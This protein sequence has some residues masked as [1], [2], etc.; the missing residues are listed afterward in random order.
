MLDAVEEDDR[1]LLPVLLVELPVLEDRAL[2][3]LHVRSRAEVGDDCVDHAGRDIAQVAVGLSDDGELNLGHTASLVRATSMVGMASIPP[4]PAEGRVIAFFDVDNTLLRGASI[5]HLGRGAFRRRM[6]TVSDLFVFGWQQ[7]RFIAVGENLRHLERVRERALELAGGHSEADLIELANEVYDRYIRP[8]LWP[9][10]VTL[11]QDHLRRGHEV[12]LITATPTAIA[13]VIA[14]RL[15]LTGA[16]GTE[17]EAVDGVLTGRLVGEVL[18][19]QRKAQAAR[20]LA[21]RLGVELTDSWAYSDSRNDIP[22][23][24]LVGH[25]VVVNPDAV[26]ARH[27]KEH[28]WSQVRLRLSSIRAARRSLRDTATDRKRQAG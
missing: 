22:L 1:D 24:S 12:W 15:G 16:L 21:E 10:S 5:Y 14:G 23:L 27:A 13:E 17:I 11:A 20:Q 2:L 4:Q 3:D 18:H 6:L 19:G 8:K 28:G 26:L 9:E 7:L 25:P